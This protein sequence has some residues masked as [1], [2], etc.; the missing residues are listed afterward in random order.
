MRSSLPI[1]LGLLALFAAPA[2][3]AGWTGC[4]AGVSGGLASNDQTVK[5]VSNFTA[6]LSAA[7]GAG[8]GYSGGVEAG[9]DIEL[10]QS[11]VV[12]L[13]ATYDFVRATSTN[14]AT[15]RYQYLQLIVDQTATVESKVT[16]I[17]A[18]TGRAGLTAGR[19]LLF[20]RGGAALAQTAMTY[21]YTLTSTRDGEQHSNVSGNRRRIGYVLGAGVEMEVKPAFSVKL[22]YDRYDFGGCNCPLDGLS[23]STRNGFTYTSPAS[24][25][26][27]DKLAVNAVKAGAFY[28]F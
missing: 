10:P 28:R 9:C 21:D 15:D 7:Q 20:V 24:A 2:A 22:E 6:P 5:S 17:A 3:Q 8:A 16:S 25:K 11:L 18:V 14:A 1:P 13:G 23:V 26:V 27:K 4:Q 19:F 12:G